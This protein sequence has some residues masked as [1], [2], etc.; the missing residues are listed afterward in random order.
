MPM[1]ENEL[2][3]RQPNGNG[4]E[5][6]PQPVRVQWAFDDLITADSNDL[7]CTFACSVRALPDA[8]ERRMLEEVLLGPRTALR[9]EH[10]VSH[11]TPT[12]RAAAADAARAK[13]AAA[14]LEAGA[15]D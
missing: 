11:F 13:G 10:V 1:L 15:K 8:T 7:R 6:R 14:W 4:L 3:R 5:L 12:L 2:A 9:A